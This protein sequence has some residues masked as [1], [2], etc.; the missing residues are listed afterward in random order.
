VDDTPS[1]QPEEMCTPE[2]GTGEDGCPGGYVC[3]GDVSEQG[4]CVQLCQNE[5]DCEAA[6]CIPDAI[7]G[8]PYCATECSPFENSCPSPLQCRRDG[9]RYACKFAGEGD[10]GS[11]GDPCTVVEDGGCGGSFTCVPGALVPGCSSDN[12]CT[13]LCDLSG[14]DPC[15][16]PSICAALLTNPAPGFETIGACFVPA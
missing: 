13:N 16:A 5:S 6:A 8:V 12:C 14:P 10:T 4:L 9:Q 3:L 7:E 1:L 15:T 2:L 11:V